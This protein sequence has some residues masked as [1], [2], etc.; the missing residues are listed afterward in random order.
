MFLFTVTSIFTLYMDT[1]P[2]FLLSCSDKIVTGSFDKTC[3]LWCSETGKCYHTFRGHTSE[4][5]Y[6][7]FNPQS[8]LI[9]SGSMDM[10]A[11]LWDVEHGVEKA[12]LAVRL[13]N[14]KISTEHFLQCLFT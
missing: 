12:T 4:V 14:L 9:A 13:L 8:T 2:P 1:Y 11:R 10:T 7:S 6:V 3:K 5:V